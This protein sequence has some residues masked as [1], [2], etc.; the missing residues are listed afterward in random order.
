M[1]IW[2]LRLTIA[3][4]CLGISGRYLFGVFETESPVYGLLY[5][6]L[7][8]PEATAQLTDDVGV[9]GCLI[10]G[11]SLLASGLIPLLSRSSVSDKT[12][13]HLFAIDTIAL[14][15]IAIWTLSIAIGQ[16]IRG[17]IFARFTLFEEAVRIIAPLGLFGLLITNRLSNGG[18]FP[19]YVTTILIFATSMT[20][21]F[22]GY[23]ATELYGPFVDF[24]L[25]SKPFGITI[26]PNQEA[27]EAVLFVIGWIDILLAISIV[28][29]RWQGIA[30]YMAAWGFLTAYSR[31]TSGGLDAWPE[32][33]IR[34][35]NAGVPL[36]LFFLFRSKLLLKIKCTT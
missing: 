22:H 2:C 27:A 18:L 35:A 14:F 36:T 16:T 21:A 1:A 31:I 9:Y 33:L 3:F 15:F 28:M 17:D 5:F 6:E 4:H 29:L 23:K 7:G 26:A 19:K 30:L 24:L 13:K 12:K 11:G 32:L 34:A 25:L 10:A 20:F 8:F